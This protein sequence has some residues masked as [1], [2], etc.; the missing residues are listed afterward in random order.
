M[1]TSFGFLYGNVSLGSDLIG[2]RPVF[3]I[4]DLENILFNACLS[5]DLHDERLIPI[6][7]YKFVTKLFF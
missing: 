2:K 4:D 1:M 3:G 5:V 6:G 7:S